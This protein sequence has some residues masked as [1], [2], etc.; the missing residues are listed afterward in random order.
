VRAPDDEALSPVFTRDP[1]D[2]LPIGPVLD[3]LVSRRGLDAVRSE[4][5]AWLSEPGLSGG[6]DGREG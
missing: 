6:S 3:R 5:L 1:L 2:G 4:L